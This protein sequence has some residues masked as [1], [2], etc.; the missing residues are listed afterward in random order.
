MSTTFRRSALLLA[1]IL[2][3]G[4]SVPTFAASAEPDDKHDQDNM[5]A[6]DEVVVTGAMRVRQGGAQDINHFRG[7]ADAQ[8]IPMPDT[9]T[10]E[11]LM[12]DYDLLI[13]SNVPCAQTFCLTGQAMRAN[14]LLRPDDK[15]MVGLGFNTNIDAAHWK[16][17]PL[18][19]V[20]VVDKSGSMDGEP[21]ARV[22]RSLK[23]LVGQ[24]RTGDQI[25]IVLYGD[26]SYLHLDP[27]PVT[28]ASRSK[29]LA[30]ID[31]I[32][33][34]GSTNMEEGL[35][36]G[37]DTAFATA[38]HFD[39][40]TRLMQFT[41]E[42]PNVGATDAETFMGMAQAASQRHIGLTVIGVGVQYD[43]DLA[44]RITSVRGGN[45]FFLRDDADVKAVFGTKL[46]TM[47]SELAY[48]VQITLRPHA[49][50]SL[51]GVYG[52]PAELLTRQDAGTISVTVPTAF[53]STNGG[54]IFA[55]L[56][57]TAA[58]ANLPEPT[59]GPAD[60]LVDV[61]LAYVSALDGSRASDHLAVAGVTDQPSEGLRRGQLLVDEFLSLKQAT[62]DYHVRNDP[63][64]AYQTLR[65]AQDRIV[66]S[67]DA[68]LAPERKLLTSLT[69]QTAF[70]SGHG[71]E[72]PKS[73]RFMALVGAWEVEDVESEGQV[74]LRR[75]DRLSL[76]AD[77]DLQ[78]SHRRHGVL[79]DDPAESYQANNRQLMMTDS[80][81]VFDYDITATR[82]VL[83]QTDQDVVVRLRRVATADTVATP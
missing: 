12:G 70:L 72:P 24:M 38:E 66:Q 23:Q 69:E 71:G 45:L 19:L 74:D 37:Y 40:V 25:S 22:R 82:L 76:S 36:V 43:A 16:R 75:G 81:L 6:I 64:A 49:G 9:I 56:A 33:S 53:F 7:E 63:H 59:V 35:K 4:L 77:N 60:T 28:E 27:T 48:D 13:S 68:R 15:I 51:S 26:R 47:V 55:T 67:G 14:L 80:K 62:T 31:A 11:G 58:S 42:Q 30:S 50:Y 2:A 5:P 21:L 18:N 73:A 79:T 39:G 29:I 78:V 17:R 20:A 41:D 3:T 10:A 1:S 65:L 61:D 57:K 32:A 8:R 46:D 52:V 44:T 54:G 34:A 83:R